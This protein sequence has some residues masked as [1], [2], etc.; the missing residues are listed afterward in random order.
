[1][2][3][4]KSIYEIMPKP[5]PMP[6]PKLKPKPKPKPKHKLEPSYQLLVPKR[7]L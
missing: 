1:M 7:F 4:P 2:P 6:K 3:K 5:K